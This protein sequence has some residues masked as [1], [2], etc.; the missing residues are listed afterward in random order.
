MC[1]FRFTDVPDQKGRETRTLLS[2]IPK[3]SSER[4][5]LTLAAH[6]SVTGVI[7]VNVSRGGLV[8]TRALIDGLRKGCLGCGGLGLAV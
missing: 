2:R 1:M 3:S 6:A 5:A 8:D 4:A 7:L